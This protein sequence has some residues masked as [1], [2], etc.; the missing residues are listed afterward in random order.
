M[1]PNHE[2]PCLILRTKKKSFLGN[3]YA[4]LCTLGVHLQEVQLFAVIEDLLGELRQQ[5]TLH[6]SVWRENSTWK[7][8]ERGRGAFSQQYH[9]KFRRGK[10]YFKTTRLRKGMVEKRFTLSGASSSGANL[11]LMKPLWDRN[12]PQPFLSSLCLNVLKQCRWRWKN[13]CIAKFQFYRDLFRLSSNQWRGSILMGQLSWLTH[14]QTMTRLSFF[15]F[16][17]NSCAIFMI[18]SLAG[19]QM[20]EDLP[21]LRDVNP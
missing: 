13:W 12:V 3:V 16:L 9:S 18:Q 17:G 1:W 7:H 14:T 6:I 10:T 11:R 2:G 20:I 15:F 4:S 19:F 21:S 8:K 5:V